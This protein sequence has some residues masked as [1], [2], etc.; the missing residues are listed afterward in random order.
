MFIS[1]SNK[2]KFSNSN[3]KQ[4]RKIK[5]DG[6]IVFIL[7]VLESVEQA[8]TTFGSPSRLVWPTNIFEKVNKF[9]ALFSKGPLPSTS[10]VSRPHH[11]YHLQCC[12]CCFS[13]HQI[14]IPLQP[15]M[16]FLPTSFWNIS[17]LECFREA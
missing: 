16:I 1:E 3:R 10:S 8:Y 14:G 5:K 7:L 12:F 2:R 15:A 9:A 11:H 17:K 6:K 13:N 4:N